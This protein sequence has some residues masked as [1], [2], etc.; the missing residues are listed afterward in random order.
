MTVLEN[1]ELGRLAAGRRG[2]SAADLDRVFAL[3][4]VLAER[5]NQFAGSL[6]G[7]QQQMLAIGRA[8]MARPHLLLLDEPSLGLSPLMTSEVFKALVALNVEGLTILVVEQ[9]ASRAL[10][11]SSF[12]FVLERGRIVKRGPSASLAADPVIIEHYLGRA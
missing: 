12:A 6:S 4:P 9:N 1:L 8:I 11:A 2:T 10:A 5:R 3:F 7:G